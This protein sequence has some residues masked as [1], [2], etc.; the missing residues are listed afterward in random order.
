MLNDT[1][2]V[3]HG[4]KLIAIID[5]VFNDGRLTRHCQCFAD[6]IAGTVV[7]I[8]HRLIQRPYAIHRGVVEFNLRELIALVPRILDIGSGRSPAHQSRA[9]SQV[10]IAI[11]EVSPLPSL[12]S[13]IPAC[14]VPD[15]MRIRRRNTNLADCT[16]SGRAN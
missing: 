7:R 10:A 11:A 12:N 8:R 2:P 3:H 5:V 9:A 14:Q 15:K 16:Q 1:G 6:A 13:A 4:D